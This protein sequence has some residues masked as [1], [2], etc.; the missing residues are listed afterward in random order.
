MRRRAFALL[1]TRHSMPEER[2]L[3]IVKPDA[4]QRGLAGEIIGRFERRGF[5]VVGCKLMRITPDLAAQHYG[6]HKGKP[7]YDGL[8]KFMTSG[9]VLVLAI[10]GPR[11]VE[12]ARKMMGKTFAY[13]AE[14]GTIRGDFGASRG[15]NLIH[16]S[17]S[18]A[19]AKRELELF[20]APGELHDW[21][22][23]GRGWAFN[24]ED[25]GSVSEG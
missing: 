14:P 7:F 10:E 22:P 5:Y 23:D 2:T 19:S 25:L 4:M 13:Q 1:P 11:V 15:L 3:L 9:P 24:D 12:T 8:V 16:G 18:P 21:T 17:D 6:E 20:F